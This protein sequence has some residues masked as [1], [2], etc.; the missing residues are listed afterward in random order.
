[1][2]EWEEASEDSA[3]HIHH[4]NQMLFRA[5]VR[6]PASECKEMSP[7]NPEVRNGGLKVDA[8]DVGS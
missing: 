2:R 4:I 6:A 1:L 5:F 7:G 8:F 3:V